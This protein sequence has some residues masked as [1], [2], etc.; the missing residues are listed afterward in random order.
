MA[1][2]LLEV[3][4]Q[5]RR[6]IVPLGQISSQ[7][8][9]GLNG[10]SL[11]LCV[12]LV[13]EKLGTFLCLSSAFATS[14]V[15]RFRYAVVGPSLVKVGQLAQSSLLVAQTMYLRF[16]E[17]SPGSADKKWTNANG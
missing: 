14:I 15:T 1:G 4:F 16:N 2:L 10:S 5:Q 17:N 11:P 6:A 7:L 12:S 8:F 13:I 9:D 3:K